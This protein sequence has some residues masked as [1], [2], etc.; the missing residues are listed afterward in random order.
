MKKIIR[1]LSIIVVLLIIVVT[2][3]AAYLKLVLPNVGAAPGLKVERTPERVE[4]GK[5]LANSVMA[6]TDCHTERDWAKY[7]APIKYDSLGAGSTIYG[8]AIGLP[9]EFNSKNLTP[10]HL[11]NWSDGELFRAITSG[12]SKDGHALF[13]IMPYGNYGKLDKEDIY[14]IIAYVRTMPLIKKDIAPSA[15]DF[16]VSFIIN[17]MPL[18][19]SF[20]KKPDPSNTIEYGKYLVTAAS[21]GDCHSASEKGKIIQGK[22]FAGGMH[23]NI[24][25]HTITSANITPDE[26]GIKGWTKQAFIARFKMYQQPAYHASA[27]T[28]NDSNTPMPWT[29][30]ASMKEQDLAAIYDYLRTLKPVNNRVANFV[31]NKKA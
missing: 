6:C 11:A 29:S 26:T 7:A 3:I 25:G 30:F 27:L 12:V 1:V 9:G 13:P 28:A 22:E 21:C 4:R 24:G 18:K 31:R 23:F 14:D 19:P 17:T 2:G 10:Y 20:I 5:Y 15:A 16:P 8:H